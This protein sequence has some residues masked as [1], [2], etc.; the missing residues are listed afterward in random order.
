MDDLKNMRDLLKNALNLGYEN[1]VYQGIS[2][3]GRFF[4]AEFTREQAESFIKKLDAEI[5]KKAN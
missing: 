4:I 5:K 3:N 1:I 2:P